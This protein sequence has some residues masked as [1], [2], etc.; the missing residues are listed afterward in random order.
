MIQIHY[1]THVPTVD[2]VSIFFF[3]FGVYAAVKRKVDYFFK[4]HY[5]VEWL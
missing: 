5:R 3:G 2:F 1:A 4:D